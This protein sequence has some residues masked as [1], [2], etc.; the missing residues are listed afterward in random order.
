[1]WFLHHLRNFFQVDKIRSWSFAA[2]C[3]G[4]DELPKNSLQMWISLAQLLLAHPRDGDHVLA[5]LRQ[6]E[7][8]NADPP[9]RRDLLPFQFCPSV[10]AVY[11]LLSL[12]PVNN[13]GLVVV[14]KAALKKV[15]RQQAKKL[16]EEGTMQLWRWLVIT[17]L[18]GEY[19]D[20]CITPNVVP[21]KPSLAQLAALEMIGQYVKSFCGHPLELW[22][23]PNFN[24]LLQTKSID[25]SGDE[26]SH[27]LSLRLEELRP[28]LPEA[29]V[30]GS[31][32]AMEAVD[33]EVRAWLGCPEKT[34]KPR[35]MWPERVPTAKINATKPEWYRVVKELYDRNILA[36]IPKE[37]I[38]SVDG[39][40]V[41]NGA[42]AVAK[43]GDP[44]PGEARITRFIMNMSPSNA[45]QVLMR[46][47]LPTLSSAAN[48]ASIVLPKD[49]CL[50]WSSDDQKGAFYAWRLPLAWRSLM[51]FRW[52]VPGSL[53][54]LPSE[55]VYVC[56][57]VIPMGWLNAVSLFQHLHRQ[58]G[59]Q[60]P[61]KGAG[62]EEAKE[63]RRDRAMPQPSGQLATHWI[64]YYLDD[65]DA[66]E[67]VPAAAMESLVGTVSKTQQRQREAYK[68]NGVD[69]SLKKSQCREPK[70]VRMGAEIDGVKGLLSAPLSKKHE[71][72]GF[73]LWLMGQRQPRA[74]GTL[75][76]LG[77]MVRCFEFRRPLMS[78][79]RN[80]WPTV[81]PHVRMPL[82]RETVRSLLRGSILL[83][84]AMANLRCQVDGLVSASD[85]SESG[86]GL[87]ISQELTD[88]GQRTLEALQSPAYAASRLSPFHAAGEMPVKTPR[89]PKV[90]V[91]SLFDG[92][93]AIMCA[94][95]RLPCQVVG[96]A[97]SEIDRECKR[98]VRKRWPG[99]I[100]LGKV[101]NITDAVITALVNSLG[102][103]IDILLI[104]AGSPCQDLT[105][106]L[107]NTKGLEGSR[108]KLFFHIP[109]IHRLCKS[110]FSGMTALMVENVYSMTAEA[111]DEFSTV[112]GVKPVLIMASDLTWVRRP[113]L[114]WIDWEIL[115]QEGEK[116]TDEGSFLRWKFPDSRQPHGHWVDEGWTHHG[117]DCLPT[118]TRALPR[119]SAPLQPAGLSSASQEARDRW[120]KDRFQFQVYQYENQHLLW[121][122]DNWRLPSVVERERL[123]GFD[124]GYIS[125]ALP[126]RMSAAEKFRVGCS[127]IGNTF[128]VHAVAVLCHSL[129][130]GHSPHMPPRNLTELVKN[131]GTAPIGWTEVPQFV[132]TS[133][134]DPQA[135]LLVHEILRQGDKAGTDIRLDVGIP[136]RFK[137]FPR[138]GLRTS[139]FR[140]RIVHGYKWKHTSHINALE[141]QGVVNSV[142]W[143]LRKLTN[144]RK[145]VLHLVD[146]QVVAS[147][148]AKGRTS[149]F[150][151]RKSLQKL[152]SLL[153]TAG[154]QLSIG[155]CHT[156][157]NPADIPSRWCEREKRANT[158][159]RGGAAW[160][161]ENH[162]SHRS[163]WNGT[164][165]HWFR[166]LN[167]LQIVGWPS[168]QLKSLMT[169]SA[170]GL[171]TF[172]SRGSPKAWQ[173][174]AWLAY[175]IICQ[176]QWAIFEW[177]GSWQK[178]GRKL[179][180]RSESFR[181]AHC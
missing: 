121:K 8:G 31:L 105:A 47:D 63:W 36:V 133:Q 42:F 124:E 140:W 95:T 24:E 160:V 149:S 89:G 137:A 85:A 119:R 12:L 84:M 127:M 175:N 46:G 75:M 112:L 139:Y 176:L 120:V 79:L 125:N 53:L 181:L 21:A 86:G 1:M 54:G 55:W 29:H 110:R 78:V 65:F 131:V 67:I 156:S 88:E 173:V 108:S 39:E 92:V 19:L 102:Y 27:A 94:L 157:E 22:N 74:K 76:V 15:P 118:F 98:L 179:N 51:T 170:A 115:A 72:L 5:F 17:V 104:A 44:A 62:F 155:Y 126:S 68:E 20:W 33:N 107:A 167:S 143:R 38:F 60:S 71:V 163:C 69:I 13:L 106:L 99:V 49:H 180:R 153:V 148:I 142:Q 30:G 43:S 52:P 26:V 64:Q 123:M 9:T 16:C 171:N 132:K 144:Y 135:Q 130:Q 151:L 117:E 81:M 2:L 93:A 45:Y 87:C 145:R 6:T 35:E 146:S 90:F 138:A 162:W 3:R 25:Y 97:A 14:D 129:L 100:E 109:R 18:N 23:L 141:L 172:S 134:P 34:L 174:M 50:L 168:Q 116:L 11:K 96:F 7:K 58:L 178:H 59:L 147:V 158:V 41:L 70:V 122:G 166:S 56:S 77:R 113:R 10:G 165:L 61:P 159:K 161:W 57:A 28:G 83:P 177:V 101:E 4:V 111:R 114:Y 103:K 169:P 48:W 73:T 128:H 32:D 82:K 150:R 164:N 40:L 91:L 80:C 66:P 37:E 152:N 154:I 136:F